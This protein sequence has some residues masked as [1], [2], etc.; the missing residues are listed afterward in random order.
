MKLVHFM[1][2]NKCLL[3]YKT[4]E[5]IFNLSGAANQKG[6]VLPETIY[7]LILCGDIVKIK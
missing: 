3:G 4:E 1:E 2:N 6:L 7:Q 5:G